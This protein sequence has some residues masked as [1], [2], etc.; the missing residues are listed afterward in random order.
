MTVLLRLDYTPLETYE[1]TEE[2]KLYAAMHAV[3]RV[4][5]EDLAEICA[6]FGL[7]DIEPAP[8]PDDTPLCRNGRHPLTPDN[9]RTSIDGTK[10]CR[11]CERNYRTGE[12]R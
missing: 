1:T 3:G 12:N 4:P 9:I 10:R 5:N 7:L 11:I 2:Q 6:M 8:I